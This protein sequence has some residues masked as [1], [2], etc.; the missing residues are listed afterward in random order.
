MYDDVCPDAIVV[1]VMDTDIII[2]APYAVPDNSKYKVKN[3][4]SKIDFIIKNFVNK[5]IY[6]MGDLN[7]RCATPSNEQY[8]YSVN[9]DTVVNSNGRKLL[10]MCSEND[11]VIV[12]GLQH[13][14]VK[15]DS[16]FTYY[17]GKLRSQNDWLITNQIDNVESYKILPKMI[18]SDHLPCAITIRYRISS[19]SV[20]ILEKCVD[21][22]FNYDR[23]DRSSILKPRIRLNEIECKPEMVN[24]FNHLADC[25]TESL[26]NGDRINDV[27]RTIS[28][29][30]YDI[31]RKNS[32]KRKNRVT[33][34]VEKSNCSSK[35]FLAIAEANL[36]MYSRCIENNESE[37]KQCTI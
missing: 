16:D 22:N 32:S 29:G 27:A 12:N 31:C 21:G 28:D 35:N 14:G 26:V 7:S 19:K 3:I 25:I 13:A 23:H 34:P 33:I 10:S 15:Y 30:I 9:P 24:E 5:Q 2:I 6:L 1:E 18:V 4:F 11:L 20:T 37:D 8:Q 36:H 17:R